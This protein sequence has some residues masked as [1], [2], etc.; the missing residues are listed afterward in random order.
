MQEHHPIVA[1]A[2]SMDN[3]SIGEIRQG[4][5]REII[6]LL[7]RHELDSGNIAVSA[8][9]INEK[10]MGTITHIRKNPRD[11]VCLQN[12]NRLMKTR[13]KAMYYLRDRDYNTYAYILKYYNI[14]D[15]GGDGYEKLPKY[16]EKVNRHHR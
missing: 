11:S 8:C 2:F 15:I 10:I 12:L 4:R 9:A 16:L 1:K 14:K 13:R 7:G 3:G 6:K 5:I